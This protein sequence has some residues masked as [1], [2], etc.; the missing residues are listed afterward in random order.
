MLSY[1]KLFASANLM[2]LSSGQD[3]TCN[4]VQYCVGHDGPNQGKCANAGEVTVPDMSANFPPAVI[5]DPNGK[6]ALATSCPFLDVTA[7][8][9][10]NSDNAQI[11]GKFDKR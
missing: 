1:L 11:M 8:Y 5:T 9:C 6:S 7:P 10:C 2:V 3:A 4:L